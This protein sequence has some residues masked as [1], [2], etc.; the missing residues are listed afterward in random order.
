M[1]MCVL[2]VATWGTKGLRAPVSRVRLSGREG[3]ISFF[4]G[5]ERCGDQVSHVV[6]QFRM[7]DKLLRW[8]EIALYTKNVIVYIFVL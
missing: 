5:G 1:C 7:Q 3:T 2:C 8:G 4:F 6:A